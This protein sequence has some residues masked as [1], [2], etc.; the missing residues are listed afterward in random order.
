MRNPWTWWQEERPREMKE[1]C[2]RDSFTWSVPFFLFTARLAGIF[3]RADW[4]LSLN[5][6]TLL[7][8]WLSIWGECMKEADVALICKALSDS[9]RIKIV[10]A[11]SGGEK[12]ACELLEELSLI[13]IFCPKHLYVCQP[14][15][16]K[17]KH[18]PGLRNVQIW[19]WRRR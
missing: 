17:G 1:M 15:R 8:R 3:W 7:H 16:D 12:C 11:L 19:A 2:I 4:Q 6:I 14:S 9:N 5:D 18:K 10:N 13:H